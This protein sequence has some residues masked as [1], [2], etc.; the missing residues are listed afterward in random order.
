[1]RT[2]W[3]ALLVAA[4][5]QVTARPEASGGTCVSCHLELEGALQE[6]AKAFAEDVHAVNGLGCIACHGGDATASDPAQA[7]S[8]A[9][10]FRGVPRRRDVPELCGSC[11]ADPV[12]IKRYAPNLPTDQL[13]RYRTSVHWKHV[14][15]GDVRAAVCISCHKAHGILSAKD[16][17]SPVYPTHVVDTCA[18]CHRGPN[19]E[20]PVEEYKRSVHYRALTVGQ[21]LAA[22]TCT[23]CHGS[24][25]AAPPGVDSVSMVC[26]TCH[27]RNM[28]LFHQSPHEA[29]FAAA[30]FGACK[31]CHGNH[32]ILPPTDAWI[33]LAEGGVCGRCHTT[34][35]AGGSTATQLG[36]ALQD[37]SRRFDA[38]SE[39]VGRAEQAGMLMDEARVELE[40]AR[41]EIIH[42]RTQVHLAAAAPVQERTRAA[43][44]ASEKASGAARAAFA[45]IHYRRTGLIVAL[46][47][48]LLAILTLLLHIR[49]I[50]QRTRS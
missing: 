20:G 31:A 35:D 33:S 50:E 41:Q 46:A 7:M 29:V 32:A 49:R 36:D 22:P 45:E 10:G 5:L 42:A 4:P 24:H 6:P 15:A 43:V 14:V 47:V 13:S 9:K 2:I 25:G 39:L 3:L 19:G 8:R 34:S 11:H 18:S 27:P 40:G 16:S 48:I 1:M 30:G 23:S 17:R 28:E 21:D 44:A 12:R 26:G 38:A 37:A